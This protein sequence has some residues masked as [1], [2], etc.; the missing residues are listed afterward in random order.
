M[1]WPQAERCSRRHSDVV[2]KAK[3]WCFSQQRN[4]VWRLLQQ[5]WG[6][7]DGEA[8]ALGQLKVEATPWKAQAWRTL[9]VG[10]LAGGE[11][12]K[13]RTFVQVIFI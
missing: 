12:L 11:V 3:L 8:G 1:A 7:R 10:P 6:S 2:V 13:T 5:F 9:V 4:L